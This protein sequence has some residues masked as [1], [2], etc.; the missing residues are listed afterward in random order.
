M[1][2]ELEHLLGKVW[3]RPMHFGSFQVQYG[4]NVM[5][6]VHPEQT[7]VEWS[8]GIVTLGASFVAM[9]LVLTATD[10]ASGWSAMAMGSS[11]KSQDALDTES[12]AGVRPFTV[13]AWCC[14]AAHAALCAGQGSRSSAMMP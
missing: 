1:Q 4:C 10:N 13:W 3:D 11:A 12:A 5:Y 7:A 6:D 14:R 9:L 2:P 8:L